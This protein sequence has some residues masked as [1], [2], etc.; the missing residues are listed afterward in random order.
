M[1]R[2]IGILGGMGPEA[3]VNLMRRVIAAVPASD[4]ADHIPMI[5]DNNTEVPSRIAHLVDGTGA[6]SDTSAGSN[7]ARLGGD[8]REALAM[9]CNSAHAY[10]TAIAEAVEIPFLN[11]VELTAAKVAEMTDGRIGML[12]S[13]AVQRSGLFDRALGAVGLEAVYSKDE[14]AML[15]VIREVK[16][17]GVSAASERVLQGAS[18]QLLAEGARVQLVAC[19][20]FSL[21][22]DPV[23][24][25]AVKVDTIDVLVDAILEFAGR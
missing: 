9:P 23:A 7:G 24:E 17:Q 12:A 22:A 25:D 18:R 15:R 11:M 6:G 4:D 10:A 1:P 19:S 21:L 3:T 5:V 8:G 14:T 13:P 20:E 2:R 16:Q